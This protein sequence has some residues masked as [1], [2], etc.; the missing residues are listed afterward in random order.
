MRIIS[1]VHNMFD[2]IHGTCQESPFFLHL[3]VI[4]MP[5]D[6]LLPGLSAQ[7]LTQM[8]RFWQTTLW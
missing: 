3:D 4:K 5:I 6:Q 7:D 1:I 8:F 2:D